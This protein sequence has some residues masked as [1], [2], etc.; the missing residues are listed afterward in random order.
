MR[1][2]IRLSERLLRQD[3][4]NYWLTLV[5][6]PSKPPASLK[7]SVPG[8]YTTSNHM[9]NILLGFI[10]HPLLFLKEKSANVFISIMSNAVHIG[11]RHIGKYIIIIFIII[12]IIMCSLGWWHKGSSKSSA[13]GLLKKGV[14]YVSLWNCCLCSQ[15]QRDVATSCCLSYGGIDSMETN[16]QTLSDP[17]TGNFGKLAAE[18]SLAAESS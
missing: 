2:K 15:M 18:V 5:K 12:N 7:P 14:A 10:V 11:K 9:E 6:Q 17:A 4:I 8:S 16:M 1:W 3:Q 13:A